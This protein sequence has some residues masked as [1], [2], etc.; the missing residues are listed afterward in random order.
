MAT[1][2]SEIDHPTA[3]DHMEAPEE[4]LETLEAFPNSELVLH[5]II[6]L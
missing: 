5:L 3:E 4:P 6:G 1:K 2:V